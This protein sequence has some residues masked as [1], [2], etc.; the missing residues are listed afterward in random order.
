MTARLPIL[1]TLAAF[2]SIE[3]AAGPAAAHDECAA[4]TGHPESFELSQCLRGLR[5]TADE[6]LE[7]TVRQVEQLQEARGSAR[8]SERL[9]YTHKTFEYYR[10]RGCEIRE[11]VAGSATD[12]YPKTESGI[13]V[14]SPENAFRACWIDMT[15]HRIASSSDTRPLPSP[16]GGELLGATWL[17]E[18]IG[19]QGVIDFLQSTLTFDSAEK[20][21]G[22]GGC[23]AFFGSVKI[24]GH[25]IEFGPIGVTRKACGKAIDDQERK[26]FRGL[27]Q[28]R[29][30]TFERGL[31]LLLDGDGR[32]VIRLSLKS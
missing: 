32:Q 22:M 6:E 13:H 26:F 30:Y 16:L 15:C 5:E 3:W 21:S 4:A 14:I 31:L 10:R 24:D 18:D 8:A 2:L 12:L 17:V 29:S 7:W 11:L 19:G 20:V 1:M 9:E 27:E 28:V 23:N 25:A